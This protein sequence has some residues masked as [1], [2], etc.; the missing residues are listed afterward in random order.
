MLLPGLVNAHT[1]LELTAMRGLF[2]GVEFVP[3]IRLLTAPERR[4]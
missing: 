1:H 3:W 2:P 4:C